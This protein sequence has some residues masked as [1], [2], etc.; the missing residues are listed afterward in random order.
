[1]YMLRTPALHML[2]ARRVTMKNVPVGPV[3]HVI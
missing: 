3:A 2:Y 1:M